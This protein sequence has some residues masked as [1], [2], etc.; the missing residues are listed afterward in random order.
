[1]DK[2]RR[3]ASED[4]SR[5]EITMVMEVEEAVVMG[6]REDCIDDSMLRGKRSTPDV[7]IVRPRG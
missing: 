5:L 7:W 6:R 1:M 2:G 4:Q 3:G